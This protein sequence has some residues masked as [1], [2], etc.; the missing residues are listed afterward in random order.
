V[1]FRFEAN[2]IQGAL[3]TDLGEISPDVSA[4]LRC[5]DWLILESNHDENLLRLGPYPWPL[6]QRLLSR[7][8]HLSNHS[9]ARFLTGD[10]D[11]NAG[12]LFLAHLSRQNNDPQ[13]AFDTARRALDN[14]PQTNGDAQDHWT[15]HL[16][17]QTKPSIVL[18]L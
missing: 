4:R 16:T 12:H 7:V 15:L 17:E 5:C 11:G 13:L 1:G 8:G 6:K 9:L 3:A 14:R 2:G 10:F 18:E